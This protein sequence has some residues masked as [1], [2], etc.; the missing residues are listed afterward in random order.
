MR[1]QLGILSPELELN[2]KDEFP[3]L[4]QKMK[5][6]AKAYDAEF[7]DFELML[8]GSTQRLHLLGKV[9]REL[10]MTNE[11]PRRYDKRNNKVTHIAIS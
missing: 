6:D 10:S 11:S 7:G 9:L 8:M 3:P 5:E 1:Q 4:T 2:F